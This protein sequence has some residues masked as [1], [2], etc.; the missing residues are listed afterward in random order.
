[1]DRGRIEYPEATFRL[2]D[3]LQMKRKPMV[4]KKFSRSGR[5][6]FDFLKGEVICDFQYRAWVVAHKERGV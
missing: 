1:M 3:I 2:H 5:A 6:L 4:L